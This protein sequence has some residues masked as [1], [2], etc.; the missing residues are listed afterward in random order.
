MRTELKCGERD[1]GEREERRRGEGREESKVK[2]KKYNR[3]TTDQEKKGTRE[4]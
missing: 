3:T 2:D 4:F 1:G